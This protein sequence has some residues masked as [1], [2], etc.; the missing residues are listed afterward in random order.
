MENFDFSRGASV[1]SAEVP[2]DQFQEPCPSIKSWLKLGFLI[3]IV[4][5]VLVFR[6]QGD[7]QLVVPIASDHFQLD[8]NSAAAE[9][10]RALPGIGPKLAQRIVDFRQSKG[11]FSH[12]SDLI[13]V[14]GL[15]ESTVRQ[16]ESFLRV[17]P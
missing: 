9:E 14:P 12:P 17:Y 4:S 11:P 3:A 13:K 5:A 10:F 2:S 1:D 8:I 7:R 6:Q 15:G 16:L